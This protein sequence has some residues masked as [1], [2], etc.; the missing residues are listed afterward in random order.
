MQSSIGRTL[1]GGV[2][3]QIRALPLTQPSQPAESLSATARSLLAFLRTVDEP[4]FTAYQRAMREFLASPAS[5][6][7][8][9]AHFCERIV[10]TI[11]ADLA[12]AG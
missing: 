2:R 10:A 1:A 5:A 6:R 11:V 8:G 9:N 3:R 4:R 7:F 12:G